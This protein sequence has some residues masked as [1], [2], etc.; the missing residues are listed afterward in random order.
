MDGNVVNI[1]KLKKLNLQR[2]DKIFKV[3]V[4]QI[5]I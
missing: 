3:I 5:C 1:N 2:I 4:S